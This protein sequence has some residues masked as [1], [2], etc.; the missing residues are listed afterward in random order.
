MNTGPS[1]GTR[2]SRKAP[3]SF[4]PDDID[5]DD[6]ADYEIPRGPKSG[7]TGG[8]WSWFTSAAA[9]AKDGQPN[10]QSSTFADDQF[11]RAFED[12]LHDDLAD[13]EGENKK[14]NGRFWALTGTLAGATLGFIIANVP[15]AAAGGAAGN[16]LGNLR[17]VKG[18]SVY[19]TFQELPQSEKS[20]LL[21]ELAAKLF[22][23][24]IS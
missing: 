22:A 1:G 24:A 10:P 11:G 2:S 13:G 8:F 21:S 15:G 17:D 6:D 5:E 7:A 4:S 3:G 23:G 18:Q 16:R 20:K 14:P 12:M 9:G 19:S